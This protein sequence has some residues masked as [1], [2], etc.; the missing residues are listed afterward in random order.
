VYLIDT[1]EKGSVYCINA[2]VGGKYREN[3]VTLST[4]LAQ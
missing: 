3:L 2:Q 1:A 4:G